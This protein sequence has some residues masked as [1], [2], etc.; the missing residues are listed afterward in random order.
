MQRNHIIIAAALLIVPTVAFAK[1]PQ[2]KIRN[3]DLKATVYLPDAEKGYYR[4]TRFDWSG[5]V[6]SLEYLGHQYFGEWFVPLNGYDPY[7]HDAVCGPAESFAAIGFD[8]AA[9]GGE[10]LQIGVGALRRPDDG[11]YNSFRLYEI[12]NPGKWTVKKSRDR[13][14]FTHEIKDAAGYSYL[15][16][17]TICLTP[18]KPEMTL[19]HSLKN[20]GDRDI[21]TTCFNHNFFTIDNQPTGPGIEVAF[22]FAIDGTWERDNGLGIIDGS[23]VQYTR[24]FKPGE[25]V[26]VGNMKNFGDTPAGYDFRIENVVTGAG[27]RIRGDQPLSKILFWACATASCPE[28]YI[29]INIKPGEEFAWTVAYEFYTF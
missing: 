9:S 13:I 2:A 3:G 26:Y 17:K 6:P 18:G 19:E 8:E 29:D 22:P 23:R 5:L 16:T 1:P 11:R 4:A 24:D 21:A 14:S 12:S 27:V 28:P 25:S 7:T 10:F 15:Y 20:T